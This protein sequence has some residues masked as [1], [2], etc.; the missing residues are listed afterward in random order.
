MR[1]SIISLVLLAA[2][3][4][5][6]SQSLAQVPPV[7][8]VPPNLPEKQRQKLHSQAGILTDELSDLQVAAGAFNSKCAKVEVGSA[9]AGE[10]ANEQPTIISQKEHYISGVN[11]FQ[12]VINDAVATSERCGD[13]RYALNDTRRALERQKDASAQIADTSLEQPGAIA[14][15]TSIIAARL[16]KL[17]AQFTEVSSLCVEATEMLAYKQNLIAVGL[18]A[19]PGSIQAMAFMWKGLKAVQGAQHCADEIRTTGSSSALTKKVVVIA[20][21]TDFL[22]STL[23]WVQVN[24]PLMEKIAKPLGVVVSAAD[25]A[26][27]ISDAR[28]DLA[29][30]ELY[31]VRNP[32]QALE[33]ANEPR[34]LEKKRVAELKLCE[35]H[36]DSL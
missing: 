27:E 29:A 16:G 17:A 32:D 11:A 36:L 30:V 8:Q 22:H 23:E 14:E 7:P 15:R 12:A 4:L 18:S 34:A 33:A 1:L 26:N 9:L 35:K 25:L 13:L 21:C 3:F 2:V 19:A 6:E 24:G 5:C 28:E 10:C 20:N 31:T